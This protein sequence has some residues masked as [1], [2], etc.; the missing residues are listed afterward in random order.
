M[1]KILAYRF[2]AF[3]DIAMLVPVLKEFLDENPDTEILMVSRKNFKDLFDG[4]PRLKFKGVDLKEYNGFFGL[5][6][7]S[8]EILS[9]FQPD[10]VADFHNVLRSNILNFFFWLKR[11]PIHKI[12]KGRKE[13]KQLIDTKNLNKTQLKK[14]TER[15][16][17]V[18]RKMGFSLTLSHQLKPQQGIKN[19]VGFAPF[20]QHFG[21]MLP[22][23][24]SF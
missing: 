22:L 17:E 14:N 13:K 24:M 5:K 15:Y 8:N 18:L 4:I 1:T 2:S 3:G 7:L 21:K 6:K 20:A 16:A 9:E 23:E 19:G 12:D 11:L 10:M